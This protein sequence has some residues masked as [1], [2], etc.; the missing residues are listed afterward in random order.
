MGLQVRAFKI[1]TNEHQHTKTTEDEK[2]YIL[3]NEQ[4]LIIQL[5][6]NLTTT[7]IHPST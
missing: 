3:N 7:E 2:V 4:M 5:K 6:N 1:V